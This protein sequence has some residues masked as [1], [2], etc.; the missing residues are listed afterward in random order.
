MVKGHAI[1]YETKGILHFV[2]DEESIYLEKW[3]WVEKDSALVLEM[4]P[5]G[6]VEGYNTYEWNEVPSGRV[7]NVENM[8]W[9]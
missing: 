8:S 2:D 4:K 5:T 7:R 3:R 1:D 9:D 6:H